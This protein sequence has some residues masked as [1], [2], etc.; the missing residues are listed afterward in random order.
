MGMPNSAEDLS[1]EFRSRVAAGARHLRNI[2]NAPNSEQKQKD[3]DDL[4]SIMLWLRKNCRRRDGEMDLRGKS[5]EYTQAIGLIRKEAGS[6]GDPLA[7]PAAVK[8]KV[9]ELLFQ[10]PDI[11]EET[12]E[13]Y[14]FGSAP[15]HIASRRRY[16]DRRSRDRAFRRSG[17]SENISQLVRDVE[18]LELSKLDD[19]DEAERE[20]VIEQ[21]SR[22][23][24]LVRERR[25][26]IGSIF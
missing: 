26:E 16:D 8:Y 19:A 23:E 21:L 18:Q 4:A 1:G 24:T 15:S 17:L 20:T 11:S 5:G 10:D 9:S 7:V 2:H 13:S 3:S 12:R 14:G 25:D 6:P 22:L